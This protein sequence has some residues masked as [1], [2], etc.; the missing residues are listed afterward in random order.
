M[1]PPAYCCRPSRLLWSA[2]IILNVPSLTETVSAKTFKRTEWLHGRWISIAVIWKEKRN[3]QR[4][5]LFLR[6]QYSYRH[7]LLSSIMWYAM[8]LFN[9]II[10]N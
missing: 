3:S 1:P 8:C 7:S 9:V 6:S 10:P 2:S 4:S 5:W